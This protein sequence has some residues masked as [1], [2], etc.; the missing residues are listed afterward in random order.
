MAIKRHKGANM[1]VSF[2]TK[3][4]IKNFEWWLGLSK[5]GKKHRCP[6]YRGDAPNDT[7][8]CATGNE[9]LKRCYFMFP[10]WAKRELRER[11]FCPCQEKNP[12][13]LKYVTRKAKQI[14]KQWREE[15]D[16]KGKRNPA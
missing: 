4:D 3:E 14:V 6:W 7:G 12:L 9:F 5:W 2:L 1:D 15:N 13:S 16:Q 10:R 11:G 8:G